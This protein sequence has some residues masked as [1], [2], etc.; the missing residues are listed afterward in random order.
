[1]IRFA[2]KDDLSAVIKIHTDSLKN[3]MLPRLGIRIMLAYYKK[4]LKDNYIIAYEK[5]NRIFGFLAL[6]VY[7]TGTL[8]FILHNFWL[9]FVKFIQHPDLLMQTIWMAIPSRN[10]KYKYPEISFIAIDR[11][12][13]KLGIGSNLINFACHFLS[14]KDYK[15]I[16]V[17]T[18]SKN[19]ISNQ[20]YKKNEF[21]HVS[22]EKRFNRMLNIY[23]REV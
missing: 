16:Q 23:L 5:D 2:D 7:S 22:A 11:T 15:Y 12:C 8:K 14:N 13:R 6:T 3:D 17:R 18:D 20:F 19:A 4:L 10:I 9:F 21:V 1:M